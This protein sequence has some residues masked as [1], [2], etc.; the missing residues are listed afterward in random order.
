MNWDTLDFAV[1]GAMLVSVVLIYAVAKR[2]T[3][4]LAYRIAVG[5]SLAT[6]FLLVWVNG[7]VGIIGAEGNDANLMFFGVL[8]VAVIGGFMVRF[9]PRGMVHALY[10]TAL[11]Q[12]LVAA[13]A[14]VGGRG[15]SA[16]DWPGDILMLTGMF[17]LLWMLSAWLFRH[18]ARAQH[19][20]I[21]EPEV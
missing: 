11:A 15:S 13:I 3:D 5:V 16:P 4:S 14:L 17:V 10:A 19:S 7:A 18:A 20:I 9:Q 1:F 21:D 8:A 12:A 2:M 6:A